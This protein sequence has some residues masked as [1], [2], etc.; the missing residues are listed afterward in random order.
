MID[1]IEDKDLR[2]YFFEKVDNL[3]E[4]SGS[5]KQKK[6]IEVYK[7]IASVYDSD[8]LDEETKDRIVKLSGLPKE[9]IEY[10]SK[11]KDNTLVKAIRQEEKLN[12]MERK[13]WLSELE[14]GRRMV[15]DKQIVDNYTIDELYERGLLS[16][17]ERDLLKAT[18]YDPVEGKFF[19]DRDYKNKQASDAYNRS[20]K[21]RKARQK[22]KDTLES[23]MRKI[24]TK[25]SISSYLS[26]SQTAKS[27]QNIGSLL[28]SKKFGKNITQPPHNTGKVVK[29]VKSKYFS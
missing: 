24:S 2:D 21:D 16:D 7:K 3:P 8:T 28:S 26:K 14:D 25:K 15:G 19:M 9:D 13:D 10:Y 4:S 18:K 17:S 29:R 23:D 20:K 6:Q 11:A 22:I 1:S 12:T 27:S 5:E